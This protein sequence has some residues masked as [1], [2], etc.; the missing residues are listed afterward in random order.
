MLLEQGHKNLCFS[1]RE[2]GM[3]KEVVQILQPFYNATI[4]LQGEKTITIGLVVP[5]ILALDSSLEASK[6]Y[7]YSDSLISELQ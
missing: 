3:L 7:R 2:Q 1:V 5:S 4:L 6:P